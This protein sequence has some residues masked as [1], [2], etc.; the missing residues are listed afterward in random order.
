M[1]LV[2]LLVRDF[3]QVPVAAVLAGVVAQLDFVHQDRPVVL[4]VSYVR[5]N[6]K[7]LRAKTGSVGT[8]KLKSLLQVA[9]GCAAT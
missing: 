1:H 5:N 8:K 2:G 3:G 9:Q 7:N 6:Y 4:L